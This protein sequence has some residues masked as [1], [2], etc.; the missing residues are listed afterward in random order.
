[1]KE[2]RRI[3]KFLFVKEGLQLLAVSA[4]SGLL[5]AVISFAR[6][7]HRA[8]DL[9]LAHEPLPSTLKTDASTAIAIIRVLQGVLAAISSAALV[10]SFTYLYWIMIGRPDG[11]GVAS[12]LALTPSTTEIGRLR[13]LFGSSPRFFTRLLGLARCVVLT[14]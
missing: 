4:S 5:A 11:L 14:A 2:L 13:L 1:M 6:V 10:K 3:V 12:L 7:T 9:S 8:I